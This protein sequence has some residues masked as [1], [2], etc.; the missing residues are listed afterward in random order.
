MILQ[1]LKIGILGLNILLLMVINSHFVL[2][3]Y[4][5]ILFPVEKQ[6]KCTWKC[7]GPVGSCCSHGATSSPWRA[8]DLALSSLSLK[9]ALCTTAYRCVQGSGIPGPDSL[10]CLVFDKRGFSVQSNAMQEGN[11]AH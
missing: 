7:Q 4:G 1:D 2:K 9:E 10:L 3:L 8:V 11:S 5:S 6:N